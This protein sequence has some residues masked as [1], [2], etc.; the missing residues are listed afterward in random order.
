MLRRICVT[1]VLAGSAL[2]LAGCG[3]KTGTHEPAAAATRA[4][5]TLYVEGMTER[6]KLT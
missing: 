3:S 1:I 6:L 2:V 4:D 5:V